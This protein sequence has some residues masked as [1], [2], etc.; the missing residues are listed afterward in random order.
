MEI[1]ELSKENHVVTES[2]RQTLEEYSW[3]CFFGIIE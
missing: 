2:L 3:M 1:A